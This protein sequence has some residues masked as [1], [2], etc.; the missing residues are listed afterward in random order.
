MKQ[1]NAPCE[2]KCPK[3]KKADIKLRFIPFGNPV[4]KILPEDLGGDLTCPAQGEPTAA[5]DC[6]WHYCRDC[7]CQWASITWKTMR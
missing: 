1:S 6:I 7:R 5:R 4:P 3:C 2:Q